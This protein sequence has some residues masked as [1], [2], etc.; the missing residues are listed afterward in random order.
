MIGP[1]K[2]YNYGETYP[3]GSLELHFQVYIPMNWEFNSRWNKMRLQPFFFES[4]GPMVS[5]L[6]DL[7]KNIPT[8]M[9]IY[10]LYWL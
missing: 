10:Q 1:K 6:S 7:L 9:A 3:L 4:Y 2:A 5:D 8:V